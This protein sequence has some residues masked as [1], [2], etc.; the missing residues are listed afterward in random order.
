MFV[1]QWIY[2]LVDIGVAVILY[3]YIGQV[4]PGLHP[5]AAANYSLF[6]WIKSLLIPSFRRLQAPQE[7]IILT[8]SLAK[9]DMEMMQLTK[10]NTDFASRDRYHHSSL[11]SREEL[12]NQ[13]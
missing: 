10:E 9:V 5:G 7:Q 8:P 12:I 11:V 4:S 13:F 1:I 3:F 6:R 2:A